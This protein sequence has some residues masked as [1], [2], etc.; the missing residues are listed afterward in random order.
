MQI[1]PNTGAPKIGITDV[2]G[3][4]KKFMRTN[5]NL[6]CLLSSYKQR[7]IAF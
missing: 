4:I 1:A 2:F 7:D 3:Y 6:R 5:K